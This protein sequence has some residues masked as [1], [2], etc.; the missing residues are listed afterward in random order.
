MESILINGA[1]TGGVSSTPL[2]VKANPVWYHGFT[3]H[4]DCGISGV[5]LVV[6]DSS[7]AGTTGTDIKDWYFTAT[8]GTSV[9]ATYIDAR[10]AKG[11]KM[12]A[13]LRTQ[14]V[15]LDGIGGTTILIFWS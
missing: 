13:G 14:V 3:C 2:V 11:M 9:Q 8:G 10:T 12:D 15:G 6:S 7:A 5:T 4:K 1:G